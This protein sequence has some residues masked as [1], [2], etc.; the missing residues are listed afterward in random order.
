MKKTIK[1][2]LIEWFLTLDELDRNLSILQSK[3]ASA[4]EK[5][6]AFRKLKRIYKKL[7]DAP[8]DIE[9]LVVR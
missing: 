1:K 7:S 6:K 9:L 5:D 3:G 2:D 8:A 4:S